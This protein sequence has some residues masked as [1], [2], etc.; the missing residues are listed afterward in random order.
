MSSRSY[1]RDNSTGSLILHDQA[2]V[3]QFL[4]GKETAVEI[5]VMKTEIDTLKEQL[6]A[7]RDLLI[8]NKSN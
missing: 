1:K 4:K 8:Q 2:A 5:N 7:L 6:Q 3:E